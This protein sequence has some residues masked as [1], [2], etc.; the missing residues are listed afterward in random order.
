MSSSSSIICLFIAL[1]WTVVQKAIVFKS[2]IWFTLQFQWYL[3]KEIAKRCQGYGIKRLTFKRKYAKRER[4]VGF[5]CRPF[6]KDAKNRFSNATY[7]PSSLHNLHNRCCFL[8]DLYQSDICRD[9]QKI[10]PLIKQCGSLP[11]KLYKITKRFQTPE[12]EK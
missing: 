9:I 5:V 7:L 1:V 6:N 2:L 3:Y 12:F 10:E 4:K 8:S 11:W